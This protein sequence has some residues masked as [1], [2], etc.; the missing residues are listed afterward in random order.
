MSIFDTFLNWSV[1]VEAL[2]VLLKGLWI[3]IGL[4]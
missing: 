4:G 1:F 3:T 2:P